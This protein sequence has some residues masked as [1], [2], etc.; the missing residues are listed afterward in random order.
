MIFVVGIYAGVDTDKVLVLGKSVDMP[1]SFDSPI[2]F[3]T[4]QDF[5]KLSPE[6]V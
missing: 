4:E 5:R 1:H 3:A 2:V 6:L